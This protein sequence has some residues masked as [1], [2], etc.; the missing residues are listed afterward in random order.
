MML[1]FLVREWPCG[2]VFKPFLRDAQAGAFDVVL[3]GT[4]DRISHDQADVAT[5][6]KRLSFAGV[7]IVTLAEGEI[8][9]LHVGLKGTM[10]AL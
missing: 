10:N 9:K 7:I 1:R 4:L 2:Q 8:N 3:A 5:L 6:F